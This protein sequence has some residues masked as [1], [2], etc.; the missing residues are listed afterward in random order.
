MANESFTDARLAAL[1]DHVTGPRTDLAPYLRLVQEIGARRVVDLGCGTGALALALARRGVRVWAADPARASLAVARA[2][3]GADTVTW[4][5]GDATALPT[6]LEADTVLMTGNTAQEITTD[7]AWHTTLTRAL[8]TLR[9]GG[10]LALETRDPA[11]RAWRHWQP[12]T[13]RTVTELPDG[14]RVEHW[15]ELL[16]VDQPLVTFRHTYRFHHNGQ[17]ITSTS[18]LRFRTRAQVEADL[19]TAGFTLHAVRG[20]PDRPGRELVFHAT[21]PGPHPKGRDTPERGRPSERP[22]GRSPTPRR[23]VSLFP[24]NRRRDR[25]RPP[26]TAGHHRVA[27]GWCR[28]RSR[29]GYSGWWSVPCE[30]GSGQTSGAKHPP[31]RD[32]RRTSPLQPAGI[33]RMRNSS[34]A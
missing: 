32:R 33:P 6:H 14:T 7:H 10:V 31:C 3:P 17:E 26:P 29:Q 15:L 19:T 30:E 1:Y 21:H 13:T 25:P 22:A 20:A 16:A 11:R 9:P 28:F 12:D 18:T 24:A 8:H 23:P 2:K 34:P 4:I 27:A 5:P